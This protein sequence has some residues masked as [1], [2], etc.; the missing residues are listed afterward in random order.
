M[1][2]K[3]GN[4]SACTTVEAGDPADSADHQSG[5]EEGWSSLSE[6]EE[7]IVDVEEFRRRLEKV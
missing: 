5:V 1:Y 4:L 2:H 7:D 6:G 3:M